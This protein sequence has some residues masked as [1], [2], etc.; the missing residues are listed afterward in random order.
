MPDVLQITLDAVHDIGRRNRSDSGLE[1]S[2]EVAA[3]LDG[4]LGILADHEV[5]QVVV[6]NHTF[7]AQ[8]IQSVSYPLDPRIPTICQTR[9]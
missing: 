3:L 5:M 2:Q 6:R 4:I 9:A 8:I 1:I 7:V